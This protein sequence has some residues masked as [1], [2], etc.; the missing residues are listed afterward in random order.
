M[1]KRQHLEDALKLGLVYLNGGVW[2]APQGEVRI[3]SREWAEEATTQKMVR[4]ETGEGYAYQIWADGARGTYMFNGMFGQYVVLCPSL[5]MA[6]AVN[7]GAG[8][9]FTKSGT[10]RAIEALFAAVQ[11]AA[12][13]GQPRDGAARLAFALG[14]LRFG[15]PVPPYPRDVPLGVRLRQAFQRTCLL[16]T[17]DAAD[18]L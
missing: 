15:M 11:G 10:L 13:D 17:S 6:V 4:P 3:F 18:E 5:D 12:A 8:N 2:H 16:Y 7:A 9:L 14:H 1:Y